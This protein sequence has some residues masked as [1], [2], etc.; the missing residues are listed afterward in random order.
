MLIGFWSRLKLTLDRGGYLGVPKGVSPG[1]GNPLTVF[2]SVEL[3]VGYLQYTDPG[4][5]RG[6]PSRNAR[7]GMLQCIPF[8]SVMTPEHIAVKREQERIEHHDR[9]TEL[10]ES[11]RKAPNHGM[12]TDELAHDT[13]IRNG[14]VEASNHVENPLD[15]STPEKIC[16]VPDP[17]QVCA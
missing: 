5:L 16:Y 11:E 3:D 13:E 8:L 15:G 17:Q 9:K 6:V 10:T 12:G 4:C 1:G 2:W 14:A 7:G